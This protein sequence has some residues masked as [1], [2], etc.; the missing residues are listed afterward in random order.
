MTLGH[1]GCPKYS[2]TKIT[3]HCILFTFGTVITILPWY[4]LCLSVIVSVIPKSQKITLAI[5]FSPSTW[6][7]IEPLA[8]RPSW[9]LQSYCNASSERRI[10]KSDDGIAD[11]HTPR[12]FLKVQ[13]P[14]EPSE[15]LTISGICESLTI[16]AQPVAASTDRASGIISFFIFFPQS[17]LKEG[18]LDAGH[19]IRYHVNR[20]ATQRTVNS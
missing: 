19:Q 7:R 15:K 16:V 13:F 4:V 8:S 5:I 10:S 6:L 18:K 1:T 2:H 3:A 12:L 17:S 20:R 14:D 11:S 9:V